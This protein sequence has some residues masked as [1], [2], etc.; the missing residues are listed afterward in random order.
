MAASFTLS[1]LHSTAFVTLPRVHAS[2]T[3]SPP[4]F[5]KTLTLH[6][7]NLPSSSFALQA[8][9]A[10]DLS[11][12]SE[13]DEIRACSDHEIDSCGDLLLIVGAEKSRMLANFS[14]L[15]NASPVLAKLL[16]SRVE[17]PKSQDEAGPALHKVVLQEFIP[18]TIAQIFRVLHYD[19]HYEHTLGQPAQ[20]YEI[21]QVAH[22]LGLVGIKMK[23]TLKSS[24]KKCLDS[25]EVTHVDSW[26]LLLAAYTMKLDEEFAS[27]SRKLIF[28]CEGSFHVFTAYCYASRNPVPSSEIFRIICK[29]ST[30]DSPTETTCEDDG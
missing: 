18:F 14:I 28:S 13:M 6:S 10:M 9:N 19:W 12:E 3:P 1:S 15:L 16:S 24:I 11:S 22:E 5:K 27:A 29:L 17:K 25:S 23:V 4:F 21:A 7:F 2:A 20:L 30:T 26:Y 8:L